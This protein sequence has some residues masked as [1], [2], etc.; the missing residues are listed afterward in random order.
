MLIW[1]L[2]KKPPAY[3]ENKEATFL[4]MLPICVFL[5]EDWHRVVERPFLY[6]FIYF[7]YYF[8]L[9]L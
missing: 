3:N 9:K 2:T 8:M 7:I 4:A 5:Y 1:P 6:L